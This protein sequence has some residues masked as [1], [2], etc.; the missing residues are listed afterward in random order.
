MQRIAKLLHGGHGEWVGAGSGWAR[1]VGGR[2]RWAGAGSGR[3]RGVGGL[4]EW[5]GS[6]QCCRVRAGVPG[7]LTTLTPEKVLAH[8]LMHG[9]RA[10]TQN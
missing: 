10:S 1:G 4:G 7:V 9:M 3:A 8:R 6:G 2:G 5:A